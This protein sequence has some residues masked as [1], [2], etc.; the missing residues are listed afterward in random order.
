MNNT[1]MES[2]LI[3]FVVNTL[4]ISEFFLGGFVG[5]HELCSFPAVHFMYN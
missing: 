3:I 5:G 2:I 1:N 4:T